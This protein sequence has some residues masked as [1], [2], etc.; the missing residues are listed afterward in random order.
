MAHV[1]SGNQASMFGWFSTAESDP[2]HSSNATPATAQQ[3]SGQAASW[4]GWFGTANSDPSHSSTAGTATTS[5]S[6]FLDNFPLCCGRG[7]PKSNGA[8][9]APVDEPDK[10]RKCGGVEFLCARCEHIMCRQ[11]ETA[12]QVFEGRE[13]CTPC[14]NEKMAFLGHTSG[15]GNV[16]GAGNPTALPPPQPL[17]QPHDDNPC[18]EQS[19]VVKKSFL[20]KKKVRSDGS[21]RWTLRFFVLTKSGRLAYFTGM[22]MTKSQRQGSISLLQKGCLFE[23]HALPFQQGDQMGF[24]FRVCDR[25]GQGDRVIIVCAKNEQDRDD[26]IMAIEHIL[27]QRAR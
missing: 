7:A 19:H 25:S 3:P 20:S 10:C 14:F 11:C 12:V 5:Q 21:E 17:E 1:A 23:V 24:P 22:Q 27:S 8:G 13:I 2:T 9:S 4:F 26:W 18:I 15:S 6:S 16:F